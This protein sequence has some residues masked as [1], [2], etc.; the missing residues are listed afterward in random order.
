MECLACAKNSP[1]SW[2]L[3]GVLETYSPHCHGD[4]ITE[5]KADT[6]KE[7]T[8]LKDV[9]YLFL[10][11]GEGREKERERNIDVQEVHQWV[12]SC[13]L[14]TGDLAHNPGMCPD[15]E[16]NQQPFGS[17]GDT[18]SAQPHQSGQKKHF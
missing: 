5:S 6:N 1:N 7:K 8:F 9:I 2:R 17:Q 12:A 4:E 3:G 13:M 15:W 11:R 16:P 18:Q 10:D 14:P